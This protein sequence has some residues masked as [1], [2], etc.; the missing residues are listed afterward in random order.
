MSYVAA[1]LTPQSREALLN[2]VGEIIPNGF[3]QVAHH[4]TIHLGPKTLSDNIGMP[5]KILVDK[6][7]IGKLIIA[8][9]AEVIIGCKS[10]NRIPHITVALDREAGAKPKDS[11]NLPNWEP[12]AHHF[13]EMAIVLDATIQ[14]C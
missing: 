7:A 6:I 5:V 13:D 3:D 14:E 9:S 1:V 11:N 4:M 10:Q 2:L 8:V 12:L